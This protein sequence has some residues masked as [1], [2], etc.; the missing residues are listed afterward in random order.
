M[1]AE[2]QASDKSGKAPP[3]QAG[4]ATGLTS[5]EARRL[6]AKHGENA[7]REE[8]VNPLL[9]FLGYFWGP[10]P[11]MIEAAAVLSGV[12][13]R[14]DDLTII[15]VMLLIN[16]GVGFFE[17]YKAGN[18]I[19]AL[20]QRLAPVARVLRDGTWQDVPSRL[21]V[22]GDVVLVKLGNIVPADIKLL[23]GD[24]LSIDQSALNGGIPAGRQK[25][26]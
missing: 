15:I 9:K 2:Q 11:W 16:A 22:P 13:Q 8:R 6:L 1:I 17:E 10:I 7:I 18:A 21:L 3:P 23:E 5:D 4:R 20:K 24:Y 19:E 12:T 14:W 26:G 25:G